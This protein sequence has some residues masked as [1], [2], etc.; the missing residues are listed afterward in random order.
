MDWASQVYRGNEDERTRERKKKIKKEKA[1]KA[2][3]ETESIRSLTFH[4]MDEK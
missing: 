1:K 2:K 3:K 4:D